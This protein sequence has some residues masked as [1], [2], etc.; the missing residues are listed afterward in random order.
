MRAFEQ[1]VRQW[2]GG[3]GEGLMAVPLNCTEG[4]RR[5]AYLE[6]KS[7]GQTVLVKRPYV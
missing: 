5:A 3:R 4:G 6:W 1:L 7:W 2:A